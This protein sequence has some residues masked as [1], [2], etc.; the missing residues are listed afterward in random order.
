M[1]RP[2]YGG[3]GAKDIHARKNLKKNQK[4]LDHM[5]STELAA[6]LF[7]ATQTEEKLRRDKTQAKRTHHE[8]GSKV[9]KSL[10]ATVDSI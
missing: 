8:A 1:F 7:R 6:K 9:R 2:C 5:D 3:L 4:I 10:D